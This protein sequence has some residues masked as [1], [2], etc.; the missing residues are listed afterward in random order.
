ME[1]MTDIMTDR[2][3]ERLLYYHVPTPSPKTSLPC[4]T[5]WIY[6]RR[7]FLQQTSATPKLKI[8]TTALSLKWTYMVAY[9][10]LR[11]F[12]VLVVLNRAFSLLIK[13]NNITFFIL[14]HEYNTFNAM[15]VFLIFFQSNSCKRCKDT[16]LICIL[17]ICF[18]QSEVFFYS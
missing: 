7:L 16:F 8:I 5:C 12:K 13:Y 17:Y 14:L 4:R 9:L 6:P 11:Y 10:V 1:Y 3:S 18:L 15:S 2:Y